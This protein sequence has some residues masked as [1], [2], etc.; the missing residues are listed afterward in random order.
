MFPIRDRR[1]R[2]ETVIRV[3]A[4]M[5]NCLAQGLLPNGLAGR[6]V[7]GK[8]SELMRVGRPFRAPAAAAAPALSRLRGLRRSGR[9]RF[10]FRV[11]G[12]DRRLDKDLVLPNNRR[13]RS[14]TWDLR[15]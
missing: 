7:H 5:R 15:L 4:F 1:V 2:S 6:A 12:R 10:G 14:V 3:M 8:E 9:Q 13:G 11:L